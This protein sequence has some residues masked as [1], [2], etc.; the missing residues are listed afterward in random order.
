MSSKTSCPILKCKA[1]N[2]MVIGEWLA[3][4]SIA[5]SSE[6][7]NDE[8]LAARAATMWGI[9]EFYAVLRRSGMWLD[10]ASL[11]ELHRARD[12][13]LHGYN[14]MASLASEDHMARWPCKPKLHQVDHIERIAQ[15]ARQNPKSR[16][17]FQDEDNMVLLQGWALWF[18]VRPLRVV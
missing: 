12:A 5:L 9:T 7:P 10:D 18:T 13:M 4:E 17:T 14:F 15:S 8:Y 2:A 6:K 16:W 3:A 1:Y 11:T